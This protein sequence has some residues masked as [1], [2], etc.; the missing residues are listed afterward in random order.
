[1][2][3]LPLPKGDNYHI[4]DTLHALL[5]LPSPIVALGSA[6]VSIWL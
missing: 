4:R 1:V 6:K 5:P 2:H 3:P